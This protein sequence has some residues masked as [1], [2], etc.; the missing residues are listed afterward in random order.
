MPITTGRVTDKYELGELIGK[1]DYGDVYLLKVADGSSH[2]CCKIIRCDDVDTE[3]KST[4]NAEMNIALLLDHQNITKYHEIFEHPDGSGYDIVMDYHKHG[5]LKTL[6]KNCD[7]DKKQIDEDV[8]WIIMIQCLTVLQYL[9][10]PDN[11]A[12]KAIIHG[13]IKPA[14]ILF[15]DD[16]QLKLVGLGLCSLCGELDI[17]KTMKVAETL[18]YVAPEIIEEENYTTKAD[19][20]S[21]G[22]VMYKLTART[23]LITGFSD[24]DRMGRAKDA[25]SKAL[26]MTGCSSEYCKV[27]S[28]MLTYNLHQRPD[29]NKVITSTEVRNKVAQLRSSKQYGDILIPD[30]IRSLSVK[31]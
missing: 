18:A 7:D 10:S 14:H 24:L 27:V 8:L 2:L 1:G 4:A 16:G 26:Q 13:G 19:I 11:S 12:G 6:L 29:A 5:S 21:L 3:S 9:H 22:C 23:K 31:I 15:G 17:I 20:W 30:I 28:S 25:A